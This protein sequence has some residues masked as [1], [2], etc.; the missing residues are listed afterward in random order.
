MTPDK[1]RTSDK[2]LGKL[3]E[4]GKMFTL[5][6]TVLCWSPVFTLDSVWKID[7]NFDNVC[8]SD[9]QLKEAQTMSIIQCAEQC[10]NNKQCKSFFFTKTTRACLL[11]SRNLHP[12]TTLYP[13]A[14]TYLYYHTGDD[15]L[16]H[17]KCSNYTYLH[18]VDKCIMMITEGSTDWATASQHCEEN[19][20]RLATVK[21]N[22]V[23]EEI[24]KL[25]TS[26]LGEN[27]Q[28][29]GFWLYA[30]YSAELEDFVWVSDSSSVVPSLWHPRDPNGINDQLLIEQCI[31]MVPKYHYKLSYVECDLSW[32][33]VTPLCECFHG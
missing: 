26:S 11:N 4:Q 20:G 25:L 5:L 28:F 1:V 15:S 17:A 2:E 14:G 18:T 16:C 7:H 3:S 10:F 32:P 6:F 12:S 30:K 8:S 27:A 13:S 24:K 19:G 9:H 23:L 21:T 33:T 31:I 22:T 29:Y